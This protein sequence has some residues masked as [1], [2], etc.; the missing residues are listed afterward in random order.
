MVKKENGKHLIFFD[1]ENAGSSKKNKIILQWCD[2]C[3][4]MEYDV[5]TCLNN[6]KSFNEFKSD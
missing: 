5:Q 3:N 1:G 2:I 4:K 6:I